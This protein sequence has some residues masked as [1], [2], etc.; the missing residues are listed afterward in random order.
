[1]SGFPAKFEDHVKYE[2]VFL[3][4]TRSPQ[5]KF[6]VS[7][8][9]NIAGCFLISFNVNNS[10]FGYNFRAQMVQLGVLARQDKTV[11]R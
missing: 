8:V 9:F 5:C 11:T 1:M 4:L 3:Y 2:Q 6:T 7:S 10:F